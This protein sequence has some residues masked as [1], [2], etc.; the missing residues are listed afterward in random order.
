MNL[1]RKTEHTIM[2]IA[3]A[4]FLIA[5][6]FI[7]C[8]SL[9]R[10]VGLEDDNPIEESIEMFIEENTSIKIDLTPKSKED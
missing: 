2:K 4:V 7:S 8:S 10:D 9:N 1:N 5:F 3:V 6:G